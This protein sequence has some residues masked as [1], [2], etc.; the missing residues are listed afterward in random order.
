MTPIDFEV[1]TISFCQASDVDR[2]GCH[3]GD[4]HVSQTFL[5][6]YKMYYCVLF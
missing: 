3:L 6:L 5:V 2:I 1:Y 4:T